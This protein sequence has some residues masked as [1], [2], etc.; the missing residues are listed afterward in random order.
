VSE[1]DEYVEGL[2]AL[3][4]DGLMDVWAKANP[5]T[6]YYVACNAEATRRKFRGEAL[7][8][9]AQR[10]AADAEAEAARAAVV[11]AEATS[12]NAKYMLWSVVA[13][14]ASA[15]ITALGVAFNLFSHP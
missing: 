10:K 12:K 4:D 14:A 7:A 6:Y 15:V 2:K 8:L 11:T 3:S 1:L 13:A 9:E 5:N